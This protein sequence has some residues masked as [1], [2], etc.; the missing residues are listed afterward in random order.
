MHGGY[1]YIPNQ[2]CFYGMQ[3]CIYSVVTNYGTS[4]SSRDDGG[5]KCVLSSYVLNY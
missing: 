5:S 2:T 1:N 3:Y 4:L